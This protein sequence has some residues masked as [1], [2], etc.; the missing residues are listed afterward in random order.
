MA[1]AEDEVAARAQTRVGTVLRGKYHLDRVLGSGAMATVFAATHRNSKRF[2]VKMLHPE[3]SLRADL[4]TRFL[5]EGYVANQVQHPGAVAVLDDDVAEDGSAFLVME[6]LEGSTVDEL[7][8][9][10]AQ[11][12]PLDAVL[13]IGDQVLDV[14]A[15]AHEH[16]IVHRDI[17]PA[18][19]FLTIEGQVKVLDFGIARLRDAASSAATHT[20]MVL[21]TPAFMSPEQA[22]AN[23]DDI[24]AQ[25]D[26]WAVGAVLFTLLSGRL[27]HEAINAQQIVIRAATTPATPLVRV[28]PGVRPEIAQLI[29]L[30]LTFDKAE[31]WKTAAA[32]RLALSTTA[33]EVLGGNP[34]RRTMAS[35]LRSSPRRDAPAAFAETEMPAPSAGSQR[36]VEPTQSDPLPTVQMTEAWAAPPSYVGRAPRLAGLTTAQ[37]VAQD[38]APASPRQRRGLLVLAAVGVAAV[39]AISVTVV[40]LRMG[41]D[42]SRIEMNAPSSASPSVPL[43]ATPRPPVAAPPTTMQPLV[44]KPVE[45]SSPPSI[46]VEQLPQAQSQVQAQVTSKPTVAPAVTATGPQAS[47]ATTA[48]GASPKPNCNPPYEFDAAGHKKWK[49][50]CL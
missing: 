28:M 22:L 24:D 16:G 13:A 27:V 35:L 14:L 11:R 33:Q 36:G 20:G 29:D 49:I 17:K 38:G 6:L 3:L 34:S 39:A 50:Q 5:R 41:A 25:S 48:P 9:K 26:V 32:M 18:N 23:P 46:S 2:A 4:R 42:G 30:A 40:V 45:S 44:T 21:G 1:E 10:H 15:S 43:T 12:L 8:E 7:W 19:L 31:R 47:S 37:P